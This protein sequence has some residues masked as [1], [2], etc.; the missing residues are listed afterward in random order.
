MEERTI[1]LVEDNFLN[2]RLTKKVL[3]ENNYR[4]LEA[5]NAK[6]TLDILKKELVT[7]AILD[8]NLGEDEQDGITLGQQIKEEFSVPFI[9]LTAYET[10]EVIGKAVSTSPYSYL[11][12]PFKN[13]DLIASVEIAIRQSYSLHKRK[14][15]IVVKDGEY[16]VEL[17]LDEIDYIESDGNY[18]L[19]H[20]N[21]KIY[22]LRSTIVKILEELP[23]SFFKQT[24]RA[25]IVNKNRVQKF[26]SKTV[27]VGGKEIP[28]SGNYTEGI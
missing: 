24:H 13:S 17:A 27:I 3:S 4:I 1:L 25:Y 8:I 10:P 23:D 20:S 5:K 15:F 2:R 21:K 26:N 16:N 6:E 22:K 9:Y 11:T 7:L 19:F 14:P 12:K 18:L 28:V